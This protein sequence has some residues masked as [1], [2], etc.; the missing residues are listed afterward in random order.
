MKRGKIQMH[1]S[2]GEGC[3]LGKDIKW[4]MGIGVGWEEGCLSD[5]GWREVSCG[6]R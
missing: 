4:V 3:E 1:L 5:V 6:E 2:C